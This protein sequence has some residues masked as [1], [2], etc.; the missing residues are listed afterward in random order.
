MAKKERKT[1]SQIGRRCTDSAP[2]DVRE[3]NLDVSEK[4]RT[5]I[6]EGVNEALSV[7]IEQYPPH[8][9]AQVIKGDVKVRV[10][11][12]L[13]RSECVDDH[14]SWIFDLG[15]MISLDVQMIEMC[16]IDKMRAISAH[17]KS[18]ANDIDCAIKKLK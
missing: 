14:P 15:E 9:E 1:K 12:P 18:M 8:A 7:A 10:W 17:L 4:I 3:W 5:F 11:L 13:G 16:D 2:V 6:D